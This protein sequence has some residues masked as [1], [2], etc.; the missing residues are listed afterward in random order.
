MR[1]RFEWGLLADIGIPD[2]ET[3]IAILSKK[4][5][6]EHYNVSRDVIEYIA[7]AQST[8][9]RELEGMLSRA[10]FYAGLVGESI[11]TLETAREALKNLVVQD[12]AE[13]DAGHILDC[14][15]K[16][17][18]IK[19]EELLARKRTKEI[20]L[21]RQ[22]SMYLISDMLTMP[23]AAIGNIFGKDHSTVI[24]AKSKIQEDMN[25][26]KKFAVEI[27]DIKQ[28]VKGK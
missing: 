9:I 21:A 26:N 14:V 18:N 24:Y 10:V 8:N 16:F 23:L 1:S 19:K 20:A 27:N 15:C 11:V 12:E 3:K 5:Q 13:I 22:V 2:V 4:A 25:K 6:I 28:M 7:G 17:Y